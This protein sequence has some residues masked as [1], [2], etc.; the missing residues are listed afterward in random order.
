[1]AD[2]L[3]R[4]QIALVIRGRAL[5]AELLAAADAL[6]ARHVEISVTG[7]YAA[8]QDTALMAW[9]A[10]C[11]NWAKSLR[12]RLDMQVNGKE[13]IAKYHRG[14]LMPLKDFVAGA[15]NVLDVARA[16]LAESHAPHTTHTTEVN[17]V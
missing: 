15:Q 2:A 8:A 10:H 7:P 16:Q 12:E 6:Q 14:Y 4:E 11:R 13:P 5:C 3:T 1:M 9:A 17:P